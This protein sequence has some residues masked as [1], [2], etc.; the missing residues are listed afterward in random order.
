M[1][2]IM[3]YFDD[4][5]YFILATVITSHAKTV[6]RGRNLYKYNTIQIHN[7]RLLLIRCFLK[8]SIEVIPLMWLGRW[9]E[10]CGPKESL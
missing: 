7:H 5:I 10:A 2:D 3:Q 4:V 1:A 6:H 9:L 8:V